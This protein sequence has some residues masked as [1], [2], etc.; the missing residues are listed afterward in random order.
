MSLKEPPSLPYSG[1]HPSMNF[2]VSQCPLTPFHPLSPLVPQWHPV[3]HLVPHPFHGVVS[4]SGASQLAWSLPL[5]HAQAQDGVPQFIQKPNKNILKMQK[6]YKT[7]KN[8]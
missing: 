2:S 8:I 1:E 6:R 4:S 7:N 3:S 5:Q